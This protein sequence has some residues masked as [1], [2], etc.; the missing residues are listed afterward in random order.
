[1]SIP[2][3]TGED[4]SLVTATTNPV[5]GRIEGEVEGIEFSLM[6]PE[7]VASATAIVNSSTNYRWVAGDASNTQALSASGAFTSH[8][9]DARRFRISD[10]TLQ[11]I[12]AGSGTV[13]LT[14]YG[15]TDGITNWVSMGDRLTGMVAGVGSYILR[16]DDSALTDWPFYKFIFTE[17]GGISTATIKAAIYADDVV[18][19]RIPAVGSSIVYA[20]G[21]ETT[22]VSISASG[23]QESM[24]VDCR[25]A[26]RQ[27]GA[28]KVLI[29]GSGTAKLTVYGS[30]NG[31]SNWHNL[32]DR[33]TGMTA[34][35]H[36]LA[37]NDGNMAY[38]PY[39]RFV[40][41]ETGG[42]SAVVA[43]VFVVQKVSAQ[44]AARRRVL[45]LSDSEWMNGVNWTSTY[46]DAVSDA[47]V[48]LS[49]LGYSVDVKAVSDVTTTL[50]DSVGRCYEF[51]YIPAI[52]DG[53]GWTTWTSGSG[54]AIGKVLKGATPI[55]VFVAGVS[56]ASEAKIV[57]ALGAG[58][59][60]ASAYRKIKW[61]GK[62]WY[63]KTGA[64][65]LVQ[66]PH[67]TNLSTFI[68][69][70]DD[71]KSI[72]WKFKGASGWV[73]A[74]AGENYGGDGS[75]II[76][77]L[78][79]AV[80]DGVVDAPPKKL[81]VVIDLDDTPDTYNGAMTVADLDRAY[82]AM[83]RMS[84]PSTFGIQADNLGTV[85]SDMAAWVRSRTVDRGGLLYPI[86][87]AGN[88]FW[89]ASTKAVADTK[90]RADIAAVVAK[91]IRVGATDAQ[92]DAWGYMY[93]NNNAFNEESIQLGS[94][95]RSMASSPLN[96]GIISGYGWR[97]ARAFTIGG[98]FNTNPIPATSR[99][100]KGK[101]WHR[102]VL[103]VGS[104]TSLGASDLTLDPDDG[105]TGTNK[106][107]NQC[108][109]IFS[110]AAAYRSPLYMHGSNLYQTSGNA[111]GTVWLELLADNYEAGLSHVI[112]FVHGS[113]LANI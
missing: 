67:M 41:T 58:T 20:I 28:I 98:A 93:F 107:S 3:Y 100:A 89:N 81:P 102:G 104:F 68:T 105:A 15:S 9:V 53:F 19:E 62:Y 61:R 43:T 11:V 18:A 47:V 77:M 59:K 96:D 25:A 88:W 95:E 94:P 50:F 44:D 30:G 79:E 22:G 82:A 73:Y 101:T 17:T 14:V 112:E 23:S 110:W 38:F 26:R 51:V 69:K 111:P 76:H 109:R 36:Y 56:A 99:P 16:L 12:I 72:A 35:P 65:D 54:K 71:T 4:A 66:Q 83:Q 86:V 32:G 97:V 10:A 33:I 21:D 91:G 49:E 52:F 63:G 34:G 85:S 39:Y 57:A 87:H 2:A 74:C 31:L 113:K 106:F 92:T 7:E 55:P 13:K 75:F 6:T 42:A 70:P 8:P 48:L 103:I 40:V 80:I 108:S 29:S 84:M 46:D 64:Y 27:L 60:E 37:M 90:Y 5:T 45:V 24:F 1:M 78:A